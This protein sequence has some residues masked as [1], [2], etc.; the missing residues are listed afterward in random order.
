MIIVVAGTIRTP[1]M[2]EMAATDQN[3]QCGGSHRDSLL[4]G[5]WE[6]AMYQH[7]LN[8]AWAFRTGTAPINPRC[9]GHRA[10][11]SSAGFGS[12]ALFRLS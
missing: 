4:T 8:A 1:E 6:T 9:S 3:V 2:P 11:A 5:R 10:P 7:L 12:D